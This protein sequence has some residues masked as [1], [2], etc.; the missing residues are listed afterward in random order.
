MDDARF[1]ELA[2]R[3]AIGD[4]EALEELIR[5]LHRHLFTFLHLLGI[6]SK[7]IE[8][9]A[10][11]VVIQM[12]R[13][14]G[15]YSGDQAY[16]PWLRSI[17]RHVTANYWR[18]HRAEERKMKAFQRYLGSKLETD[19]QAARHL[20]I[21]SSQL[22]ECLGKLQEKHR[23]MLTLRYQHGFDSTRIA[24]AMGLQAPAVRQSLSRIRDILKS[25]VEGV[26][27]VSGAI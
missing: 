4:R 26:L 10:Q 13:S 12:H 11:E 18:T 19:S 5:G 3:S 2:L 16:L 7:D 27:R 21:D 22:E 23:E 15:R 25:C 20:E 1:G 14:I 8:E 6:P 17:A 24:G 9:V